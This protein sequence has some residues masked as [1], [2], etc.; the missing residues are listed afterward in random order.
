VA[1]LDAGP[2]DPPT[3]ERSAIGFLVN[4]RA[5][6]DRQ[7]TILETRLEAVALARG[8]AEAFAAAIAGVLGRSVAIAGRRGTALAVQSPPD[9][10]GAA[11][12]AARY[13]E[14]PR[15][16]GV[17]ILLPLPSEAGAIGSGPATAGALVLLGDRPASELDRAAATRIAG[18][19]ALELARDEEVGHAI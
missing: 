2:G 14:R 9:V 1:V 12:A 10:A 18:L 7:A 8:G 15:T 19:L 11:A 16:T 6:L 3:I 13:H 4:H 17:R 5:E